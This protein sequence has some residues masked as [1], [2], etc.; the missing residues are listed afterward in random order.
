VKEFGSGWKAVILRVGKQ[1]WG[2]VKK[3]VIAKVQRR[4]LG[5]GPHPLRRRDW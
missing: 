3:A 1:A 4:W 2:E 5:V